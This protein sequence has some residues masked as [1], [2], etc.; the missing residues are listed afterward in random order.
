[1]SAFDAEYEPSPWDLIANEVELYETSGGTAPSELV[2]DDWIILWTLGAKSGKVRK[3]PLVRVTDGEGRYAVVGSQGGAPTNPQW[4]HNVRANPVARLQD[5]P[6]VS[7]FSVREVT[8]EEKISW[9][10]RAAQVWPDYDTYQASTERLIPVF[11]L[12][13]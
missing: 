12:E 11:L 8:G 4:V 5:G 2:G 3:T 7:D 13:P 9:W 10:D 6:V 1:M